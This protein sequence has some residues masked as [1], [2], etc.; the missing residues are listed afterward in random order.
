M[1]LD[2]FM[3]IGADANDYIEQWIFDIVLFQHYVPN[4][5]YGE[6]ISIDL[7]VFHNVS[8]LGLNNSDL[9]WVVNETE[10][11]EAFAEL[12]PNSELTIRIT[13]QNWTEYPQVQLYFNDAEINPQGAYGGNPPIPDYHYYDGFFLFEEYLWRSGFAGNFFIPSTLSEVNVTG[14]AFILDNATL[15][16]PG[17]WSG[18]GLYTGLG[19]DGQIMQLMELDRLFY[20]NYTVPRQGFTEVIIHEAGHA[21]GYP[22]TFGDEICVSD[23]IGDVMGYYPGSSRYSKVRIEAFQR[24]AINV[25]T[26]NVTNNLIIL[27]NEDFDTI[28]LENVTLVR[29]YQDQILELRSSHSYVEAWDEII[30]LEELLLDI[31]PEKGDNPLNIPFL[32]INAF[33]VSVG[34]IIGFFVLYE[35]VH[36]IRRRS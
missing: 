26:M 22:H 3:S 8:H 29:D 1:D 19:G 5:V 31:I 25:R 36:F 32:E 13:F 9:E 14:Y 16:A 15:A 10:I 4:P 20:P 34:V 28:S 6:N 17:I 12:A 21:V 11:R 18:G 30:E 2:E 33:T 35:G 7:V 27:A 23:F 24:Q